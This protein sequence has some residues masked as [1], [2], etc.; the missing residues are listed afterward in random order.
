MEFLN[1]AK[2]SLRQ[3]AE[4]P[5]QQRTDRRRDKALAFAGML[6][7]KA[8]EGVVQACTAIKDTRG[9]RPHLWWPTLTA[10]V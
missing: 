3:G 4:S 9:S 6:G 2:D 5:T 8:K 7:D 1:Q 10:A